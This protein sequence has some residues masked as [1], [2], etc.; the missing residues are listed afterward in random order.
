M[1]KNNIIEVIERHLKQVKNGETHLYHC[2]SVIVP[3]AMEEYLKHITKF[4]A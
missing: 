4:P 3:M 1:N 2:K